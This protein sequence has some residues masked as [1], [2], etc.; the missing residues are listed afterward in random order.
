MLHCSGSSETAL[1]KWGDG[2][3]RGKGG[4]ACL[5]VFCLIGQEQV[6]GEGGEEVIGVVFSKCESLR[7]LQYVIPLG[8]C[9]DMYGPFTPPPLLLPPPLLPSPPPSP[10]PRT[11]FLRLLSS[12][13]L[14]TR[15]WV[16]SAGFPMPMLRMLWALRFCWWGS[17]GWG[18]RSTVTTSTPPSSR[19]GAFG[20][21]E[22]CLTASPRTGTTR[23]RGAAR[24]VFGCELWACFCVFGFGL[25]FGI[26]LVWYG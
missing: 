19:R 21:W 1:T 14:V 10:P 11:P 13:A 16:Q 26:C 6:G 4:G 7:I 9:S 2:G 24:W 17:P 23:C 20:F 3:R 15:R 5:C 12:T 8:N 18:T 22:A 25:V